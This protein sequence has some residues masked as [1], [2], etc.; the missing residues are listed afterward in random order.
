MLYCILAVG[1]G[2]SRDLR[3][4]CEPFL[5]VD[6]DCHGDC[7]CLWWSDLYVMLSGGFSWK[8]TS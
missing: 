5:C 4:K 8:E 1:K 7:L 2:A 3:H 6:V